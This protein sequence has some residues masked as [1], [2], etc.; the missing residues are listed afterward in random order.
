MKR[1]EVAFAGSGEAMGGREEERI[2]EEK[3]RWLGMAL[4]RGEAME[5][6]ARTC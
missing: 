5:G 2:G 3:M 4:Q 1:A 6:A